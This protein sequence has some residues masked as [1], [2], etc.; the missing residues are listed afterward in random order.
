MTPECETDVLGRK[1][2]ECTLLDSDV[3]VVAIRLQQCKRESKRSGQVVVNFDPHGNINLN[4]IQ[5]VGKSLLKGASG[6][7]NNNS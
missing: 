6:A 1:C 5:W 2:S 7:V 4:Q 3:L